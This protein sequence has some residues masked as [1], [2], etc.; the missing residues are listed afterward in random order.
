M[1][2]LRFGIVALV[3][4]ATVARGAIGMRPV[5]AGDP[6]L[7]E[8]ERDRARYYN[9][10]DYLSAIAASQAGLRRAEEIESREDQMLFLRHLAYDHW[11]VGS[12]EAAIAHA[13]R[14]LQL[15]T[16]LKSDANRSRAHRYL[17]QIYD[18]LNDGERSLTHAQDALAAAAQA[19]N[20]TLRI[21][22]IQSLGRC[23]LRAKD[24]SGAAAKFEEV[25]QY[26][27]RTAV[28][29]NVSHAVRD[30]AEVA[31]ASGDLPLA[32]SFYQR[33]IGSFETQKA[34]RSLALAL[35]R[36]ATLLRRLDRVPEASEHLERARPLVL[37]I[38]GHSL[39]VEFH[40]ELAAILELKRDFAGALAAERVAT[41]EREA[42]A[43]AQA[44]VRAAD[45]EAREQIATKQRSI[46]R[47]A[48]EKN[49]QT[50][51]LRAREAEVHA[52]QAD[53]HARDAELVRARVVRWSIAGGAFAAATA[54]GV[55]IFTQRGRLHAERRSLAETRRARA[56]AE[57]ANALKSQLLGIA[58]HDL[59]APLRAIMARAEQ[60]APAGAGDAK[61]AA[62]FEH[63]R[64]DSKRLLGLV[65]DLL[66]V[67]AIEGG[68]MQ[69]T[70]DEVDVGV[71]VQDIVA[72]HR[73][74]AEFKAVGLEL[75]DAPGPVLVRGDRARL[76]QA[77]TNIVDNALKFTPPGKAVRIA[78]ERGD[79]DVRI[80]VRD[81]GPGLKAEDFARMFQP[82]QTLSAVPTGHESSTGLGLHI[83]QEIV[84]RHG[85]RIDVDSSPRAGATFAIV[86]PATT[87][88]LVGATTG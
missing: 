16:E 70:F 25:R 79:A 61:S 32:L 50:A 1:S 42:M 64:Q 49:A 39:L 46:E 13:Q 18:T 53:L 33:L 63:I 54:L 31:Q 85:G 48:A 81:E 69:L 68:G 74:R 35:C 65:H 11:L 10:E 59:K 67:S 24:F 6:E 43:G 36:T 71:L 17:S 58:S 26:W 51:D 57:D 5:T 7:T 8:R 30:L 86:L 83:A 72:T 47:L 82:F 12:T 29:L 56:A 27:Q 38:K 52:Q 19:K 87:R 40:T 78:V 15:A 20:N 75:A 76:E 45:R 60:L 66:D 14:L 21:W 62:A 4:A 44:Q 23:A 84:A 41:R 55:V 3:L 22:A 34:R 88:V 37:E 9:A 28:P 77:V 80:A 2:L 73:P